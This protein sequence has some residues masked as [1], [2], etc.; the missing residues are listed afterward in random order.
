LSAPRRRAFCAAP[1]L[2]ALAAAPAVQAQTVVLAGRMGERALLVIAGR[3]RTVAVGESADGVRLLRWV[4]DHAEVEYQGRAVRLRVGATPAQLGGTQVVS[5]AREV[6]ITA[7]PGGHFTTSGA[8]N[9][10]AVSFMVDTGATLVALGRD[11]A[12]RLGIDLSNARPA[13][14]QTANGPVPV[15]LVTLNSVRVGELELAN[16]GAAVLPMPMPM[17]LLGNSFLARLQ[18]RRDNDV[19][20]LERR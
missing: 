6:V 20:R 12:E 13:M 15:Q 19:M 5:P 9:G 11:Q 3:P 1:V 18:M 14:T 17:V 7:G 2:L 10:Q 4:D 8:I 16:V